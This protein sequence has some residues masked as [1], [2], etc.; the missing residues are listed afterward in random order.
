MLKNIVTSVITTIIV[1]IGVMALANSSNNTLGSVETVL[2][3]AGGGIQVGNTRTATIM[4]N[5]QT[6]TCTLTTTVGRLP[7]ATSSQPFDC[8]ANGVKSGDLVWGQI[9]SDGGS[10]SGTGGIVLAFAKASTTANHIEAWL[11]SRATS[12]GTTVASSSFSLATSSFRYWSVRT[13]AY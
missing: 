12:V 4:P 7:L 13:K 9:N 11:Y 6:G 1:A 3:R 2:V 5:I 8:V 10:L